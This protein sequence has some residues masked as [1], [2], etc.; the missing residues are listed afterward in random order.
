[1]FFFS[2][3]YQGRDEDNCTCLTGLTG[4]WMLWSQVKKHYSSPHEL[5]HWVHE[6]CSHITCLNADLMSEHAVLNL[7][8]LMIGDTTWQSQSHPGNP[9]DY[10]ALTAFKSQIPSYNTM[11]YTHNALFIFFWGST[12]LKCHS[13]CIAFW[14]WSLFQNALSGDSMWGFRVFKDSLNNL[15]KSQQS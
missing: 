14:F 10:C 4:F 7:I 1:M 5:S 8:E 13:S 12:F 2:H 6:G 3:A 15:E 11:R 9:V